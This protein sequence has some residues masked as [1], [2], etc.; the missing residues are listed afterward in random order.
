VNAKKERIDKLM[1][2]QGLSESRNLAQRL[3]MAGEVFVDGQL[4]YKPS[5]SFPFNARIT[6][7]SQPQYVSRGGIKLE[8]AFSEFK[9]IPVKGSVCAD[10]GASTGGFTDCLLQNGA[11]KVYAI[12]VGYGQLHQS[13][14]DNNAV[15]VMERTN[16]KSLVLLPEPIDIVTIDVSFISLGRVFPVI[17]KWNQEKLM[18]VIA[19]VKPQFEVGRK[20]AAVGKGVIRLEKDRQRALDSVIE[21]AG[22]EGYQIHGYTESPI[23]G[24][25]GNVEYLLHL[26]YNPK[27]KYKVSE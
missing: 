26:T 6:I 25:K 17:K 7:A 19:L 21:M 1:V 27:G 4:V 13:M 18:Y 3:I 5:D 9:D 12:D 2:Y 11:L 24:P 15:I 10:V 16:V 20:I 23:Q 22:V 14:R 8:K